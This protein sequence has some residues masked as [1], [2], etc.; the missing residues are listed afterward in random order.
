MHRRND[1]ALQPSSPHRLLLP[2]PLVIDLVAGVLQRGTGRFWPEVR[3]TRHVHIMT[4]QPAARCFRKSVNSTLRDA[5]SGRSYDWVDQSV[6]LGFFE[7][8]TN[9]RKK[10]GERER[11]GEKGKEKERESDPGTARNVRV[12]V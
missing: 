10:K 4:G 12:H 9:R 6:R 1:L 7:D 8:T 2:L 3:R 11:E 5:S